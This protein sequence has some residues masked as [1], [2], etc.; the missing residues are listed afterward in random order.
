MVK[1]I[2]HLVDIYPPDTK[3]SSWVVKCS[4]GDFNR[5]YINESEASVAA[6]MHV[7]QVRLRASIVDGSYKPS[8]ESI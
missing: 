6:V 5:A 4:L 7:A 1:V 2:R 8:I 3:D